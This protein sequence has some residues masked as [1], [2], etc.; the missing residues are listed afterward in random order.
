ML[1]VNP[2]HCFVFMDLKM[3]IHLPNG[4]IMKK[5]GD[6]RYGTSTQTHPLT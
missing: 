3:K 2:Q 4:I 1:I 6:L 5:D